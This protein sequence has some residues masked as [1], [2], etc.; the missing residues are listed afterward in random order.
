MIKKNFV[1]GLLAVIGLQISQAQAEDLANFSGNW[2]GTGQMIQKNPWTGNKTDACSKISIKIVQTSD[3]LTMQKYDAV[4]GIVSPDWGPMILEIRGNKLFELY[5]DEDPLEVGSI[6]GNIL[7]TL[8]QEG[9]NYAFN[10]RL[11]PPASATAKPTLDTY[12]GVQN[13]MGTIVIEGRLD[14]AATA[15]Q[16]V[17]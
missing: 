6:E 9:T 10:L 7:K 15:L 5:E 14:P 1:L 11:N 2:S 4:C 12:Y 3:R 13:G 17:R 8:F 16:D